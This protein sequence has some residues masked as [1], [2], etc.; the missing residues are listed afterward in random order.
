MWTCYGACNE[1]GDIFD[2]L[3]KYHGVS[4]IEAYQIL[5]GETPAER[6]NRAPKLEPIEDRPNKEATMEDVIEYHSH[7][8]ETV[9]YFKGKRSIHEASIQRY[10]LGT[11]MEYWW[12]YKF[13]EEE[14]VWFQGRR[15]SIPYF[16][17][18]NV[19]QINKRRDDERGHFEIL[20]KG[21]PLM[22]R[23][24]CDIAA[25]HPKKF[26]TPEAVTE[27]EMLYYCL[28]P[29]Y[30]KDGIFPVFNI[31][32]LYELDDEGNLVI[33]DDR[34]CLRRIGT[35]LVNEAEACTI[36]A[37]QSGYYAVSAK[38]EINVNYTGLFSHVT[39]TLIVAQ[40]DEAGEQYARNMKAAIQRPGVRII[41]PL[42]GY[43]DVNE[44]LIGG[45][46]HRWAERYRI[47]VALK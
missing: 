22:G 31:N 34:P 32:R 35:L 23:I 10:M 14:L 29:K 38:W 42:E 39:N 6:E 11:Q 43:K 47:P 44:M 41:R 46:I 1:K 36:A 27:K 2:F 7:R 17:G 28:G 9:S 26:P 4:L 40:N 13:S 19:R 33:C 21:E 37:E 30:H 25:K 20:S 45:V 8:A 5:T 3:M 24:R 16:S 18:R 12:P 15:Y